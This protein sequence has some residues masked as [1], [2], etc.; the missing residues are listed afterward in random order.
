MKITQVP[1]SMLCLPGIIGG[2]GM[3]GFFF[4]VVITR[5]CD[6]FTGCDAI[7]AQVIFFGLVSAEASFDAADAVFD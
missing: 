5:A 3:P 1:M 4:N 6:V 2:G 7:V